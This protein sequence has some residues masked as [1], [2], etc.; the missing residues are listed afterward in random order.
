MISYWDAEEPLLHHIKRSQSRQI[1]NL[2]MIPP[3]LTLI[4]LE[5]FLGMS[6]WEEAPGHT[7]NMLTAM[8]M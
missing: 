6:N 4:P 2:T 8:H 3:G 7:Q 1:G 5:D